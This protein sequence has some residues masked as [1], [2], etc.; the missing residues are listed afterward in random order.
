MEKVEEAESEYSMGMDKGC[1][2]PCCTKQ[3]AAAICRVFWET[4]TVADDNL[5]DTGYVEDSE[6]AVAR[7]VWA[8]SADKVT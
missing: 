6:L 2:K 4:R 7:W 3:L 8:R 5:V 1:W